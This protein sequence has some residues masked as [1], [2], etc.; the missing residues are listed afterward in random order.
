MVYYLW[1]FVWL[2]FAKN[3]F[4]KSKFVRKK[5]T[6]KNDNS[7]S[8]LTT[9]TALIVILPI[10][11]WAGFRDFWFADTSSYYRNFINYPTTWAGF[12]NYIPTITKD[13]AFYTV[14]AFFKLFVHEPRV[15]FI[16]VAAIQGLCLMEFFKKYS[17]NYFLSLFLFVASTDIISFMFNGIRQFV[18]VGITLLAAP[19]VIEKKYFKA[20]IIILIA[21]LF[22]Q[23]ALLL[24]PFIFLVQ[25]EAFNSKTVFFLFCALIA[26]T[27]VGQFTNLLDSSL[28]NTQYKNVVS[29]YTSMNDDGTNPLRVLVYSVPAILSFIGRKKIVRDGGPL[30]NIC[31]NMTIVSAGFYIISMVTSG[32]FIGRIPIYFSLYGYILLPWLVNNIFSKKTAKFINIAM[33]GFYLLFYYYQMFITYGV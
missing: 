14:S 5:L 7:I 17:S 22:H 12:I 16:V 8:G 18:A 13:K 29:D 23:S 10:I 27:F 26:A 11:L 15:Y 25:G 4:T 9:T 1:I 3:I 33:I 19:F 32:I 28:E 20:I 2:I 21:S 31:A 30:I 24:L 6:S